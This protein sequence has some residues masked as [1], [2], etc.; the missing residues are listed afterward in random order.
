MGMTIEEEVKELET[1]MGSGLRIARESKDSAYIWD[2]I[3][4]GN[5]GAV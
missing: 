3:R 5:M 4:S 2:S 1:V